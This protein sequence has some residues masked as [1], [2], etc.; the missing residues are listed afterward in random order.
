VE[1]IIPCRYWNVFNFCQGHLRVNIAWHP[2]RITMFFHESDY[3]RC[4]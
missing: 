4:Y 3:A 1:I 2:N